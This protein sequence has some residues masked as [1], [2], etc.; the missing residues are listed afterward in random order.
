MIGY[1]LTIEQKEAI[2]GKHFAPYECFNCVQDINNVWFTFFSNQQKEKIKS[3]EW[4]WIFEL[5]QAEYKP[6]PAPDPFDEKI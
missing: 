5:P 4:S 6:Q 2:Q 1:Q 3:T